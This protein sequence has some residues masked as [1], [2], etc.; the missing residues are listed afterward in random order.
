[1]TYGD[2]WCAAFPSAVSFEYDMLD[3]ILPEC[4]CDAMIEEY[5][6]IGR[7]R[8]ADDYSPS[9][10]DLVMYDWDDNGVGDNVGSADH[11]GFVYA[12]SGTLMTI[13]EGNISDSVDFRILS[14][15]GKHIRGYCLPNYAAKAR[16]LNAETTDIGGVDVNS[17]SK[18]PAVRT[19]NLGMVGADVGVMQSILE[20]NDCDCGEHGIDG[21]FG[22]DTLKALI[23][24]QRKKHLEADGVC[25][26]DTWAE[27]KKF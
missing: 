24:Y 27:L 19:L 7:W 8:E 15:N 14:E 12:K 26:S 20:L 4:G 21:E 22:D 10:G 1:M 18:A 16:A 17:T 23:K 25:G 6:A 2:P 3:T 13:I 9:I 5:K 11:V